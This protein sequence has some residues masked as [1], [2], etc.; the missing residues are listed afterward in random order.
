MKTQTIGGKQY[1]ECDV[2]MLETR[3]KKD[4]YIPVFKLNEDSI[5]TKFAGF[6]HSV[7]KFFHLY[8]LSNDE[9]KEGDWNYDRT[10]KQIYKAKRNYK[11]TE[12]PQWLKVLATTDTS[13]ELP[14]IPTTF[15]QQSID[16]YNNGNVIEKCFVEVE[17]KSLVNGAKSFISNIGN[18]VNMACLIKLN[19]NNEISILIPTVEE[20]TKLE[21]LAE[22][23][24]KADVRKYTCINKFDYSQLERDIV[25]LFEQK[26]MFSREEVTFLIKKYSIEACGQPWFDKDEEWIE[27]NLK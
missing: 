2:V 21:Q 5:L 26:Q 25:D 16:A 13:L 11:P 23:L 12:D 3:F 6:G 17:D 19:E 22:L 10:T 8:I 27:K 18:K 4:I 7:S 20:N 15:I 14:Q 1:Q 9:I 24:E